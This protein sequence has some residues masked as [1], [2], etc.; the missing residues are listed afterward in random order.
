MSF[1]AYDFSAFKRTAESILDWIKKEYLGIRT[2]QASP[3]ILDGISVESYGS[4]VPINQ[5][6]SILAS[7]PKSLLITPWDKSIVA[8][9][10]SSIREANLGLSV[11]LDAQ[12]IRVSFPDLTNERRIL[13]IK[14]VK[15]KLEEARIKVRTEREKNL[16]DFD[17]KEKEGTLSKDDKFRLRENLQKLV[18]E[19][20][21]KLEELASKKEKEIL[22]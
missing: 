11:S 16:G 6:S 2:N 22:E 7:G 21:Q 8:S 9:I 12:G 19:V 10:D 17:R 20:N 14:A 15:D 3:S 5:V 18:D 4:R 1:M 13:L